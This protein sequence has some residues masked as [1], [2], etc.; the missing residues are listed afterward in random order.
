M[1]GTFRLGTGLVCGVALVCISLAG[2]SATSIV[3]DTPPDYTFML[4]AGLACPDFDLQVEGWTNANRVLKEFDDQNGNLV[5]LLSAGKGDT[6]RFTN[7]SSNNSLVTKANGSVAG[8][9]S[10]LTGRTPRNSRATTC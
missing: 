2:A 1:T 5:R 10:T 7:L 8:P 4:P 9:S 3:P 6:L